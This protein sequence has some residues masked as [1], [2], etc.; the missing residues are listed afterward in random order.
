MRRHVTWIL[1][2]V[3]ILAFGVASASQANSDE[4]P[5]RD[6]PRPVTTDGVPHV[7][8]DVETMPALRKELLR[9]VA[10]IPHLEIRDT[11]ISLPGTA[12]FW[13]ADDLPLAN[14]KAIVGGREFAHLHPDG[15]LHAALHPDTAKIAVEKGWAIPHPW[16][17]RRPG[18]EGFVMIYSPQSDDEL[19]VVYRLVVESYRF[20]TGRDVR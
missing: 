8:V 16:S 6:A 20:I 19:D 2:I 4:I 9:R 11:V 1:S 18:W 14:P 13:L 17:T 15:S 12:G 10:E 7:Q 5:A 3:V